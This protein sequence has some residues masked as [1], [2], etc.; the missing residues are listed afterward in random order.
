MSATKKDIS[1]EEIKKNMD[2][3]QLWIE[4]ALQSRLALT[5]D[6][7]QI[8]EQYLRDISSLE[9]SEDLQM[10]RNRAIERWHRA[11][12]EA[13]F[14]SLPKPEYKQLWIET[15]EKCKVSK[16]LKE[17]INHWEDYMSYIN[18]CIYDIEDLKIYKDDAMERID[19]LK[20]VENHTI[21]PEMDEFMKRL[22]GENYDKF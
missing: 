14:K 5:E 11:I 8:W 19:D 4:A 18:D 13:M 21:S 9:D 6:I 22:F 12:E 16:T 3:K 20:R 2:F 15:M 10:Y 7:P 17:E 1:F